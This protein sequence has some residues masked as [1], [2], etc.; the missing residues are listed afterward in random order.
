MMHVFFLQVCEWKEPEELAQ[1]LDL[2][3]RATGE[4][5]DRLLQRVQD[6]A[7]YSIKTSKTS[8]RQL[9]CINIKL[10]LFFIRL[11]LFISGHP[12]FLNQQFA[13]VDYHALAGRFLTE[14]LNTN[15]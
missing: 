11:F 14:A 8:R 10:S 7:K 12:R 4:P 3:L 9:A 5:Q 2:E 15:L 6:V 13:G 1:L